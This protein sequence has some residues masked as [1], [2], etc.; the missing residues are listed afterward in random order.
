MLGLLCF[1]AARLL[2][3]RQ[4]PAD[5]YLLREGLEKPERSHH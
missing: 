3:A 2:S 4:V 1:A 5:T